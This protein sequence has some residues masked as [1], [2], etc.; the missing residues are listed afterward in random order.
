[1]RTAAIIVLVVLLEA[2]V[3]LGH[4]QQTEPVRTTR[5]TGSHKAMA[6]CVQQRLG[7]KLQEE[8]FGERYVI[9]EAVKGRSYDGLTHYAVTVRRLTADE[10][11]AEWRIM[12]TPRHGTGSRLRSAG[13]QLSEATV[14][15]FWTPVQECAALV[16]AAQ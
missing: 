15:E 5:F 6:Q 9:Y 3:K 8:S 4:I 16:K 13:P 12:A 10:G 14:Q 1:M 7:G 2:C 11:S